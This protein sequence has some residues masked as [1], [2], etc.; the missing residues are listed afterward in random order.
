MV[1]KSKK[2][3]KR[4]LVV[5]DHPSGQNLMAHVLCDLG[6]DYEAAWN[7]QEAVEKVLANNFDLV[8]MD[9]HMSKMSGYE[10]TRKIRE[11]KKDIPIFALT[12]YD[13]DEVSSKCQAAGMT[14]IFSK[15]IDIDQFEKWIQGPLL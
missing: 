10:A 1:E 8:L 13:A 7:G 6:Y 11:V 5:D 3:T 4:V 9:L 12:A 2:K 15:P 14:G